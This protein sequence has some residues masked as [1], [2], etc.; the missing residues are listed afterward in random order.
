MKNRAPQRRTLVQV[1]QLFLNGYLTKES[2][3]RSEN[4]DPF[5]QSLSQFSRSIFI[6]PHFLKLLLILQSLRHSIPKYYWLRRASEAIKI[7]N[8][9][10]I[11][12][13]VSDPRRSNPHAF[14]KVLKTT[15]FLN[16]ITRLQTIPVKKIRHRLRRQQQSFK[17][18]TQLFYITYSQD[19]PSGYLE[20]SKKRSWFYRS[21]FLN[22]S[23]SIWKSLSKDMYVNA[24]SSFGHNILKVGSK[25]ATS[26]RGSTKTLTSRSIIWSSLRR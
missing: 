17:L 5:C 20:N 9:E 23:K 6:A 25:I 21:L 16:S 2:W 15:R 13:G 8:D 14:E 12:N 24:A 3:S 18:F 11:C 4:K 26:S 19:F 10:M 22:A 7:F 1:V